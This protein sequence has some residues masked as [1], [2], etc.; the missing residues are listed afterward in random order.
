MF[1][2]LRKNLI[3]RSFSMN[4]IYAFIFI[5][6]ILTYPLLKYHLEDLG[7]NVFTSILVSSIVLFAVLAKIASTKESVYYLG[8]GNILFEGLIGIL[9]ASIINIFVGEAMLSLLI[10]IESI[11]DD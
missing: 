7:K 8:L 1:L 5:D 10:S 3:P 4:F 11:L 2:L 6:G 9:I